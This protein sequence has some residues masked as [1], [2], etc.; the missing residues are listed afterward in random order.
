MMKDAFYLMLNTAKETGESGESA[1]GKFDLTHACKN[2][3][4]GYK[5]IGNLPVK[6]VK[7]QK[8]FIETMDRDYLI[9]DQLYMVFRSSTAKIPDFQPV[10]N[11]KTKA[12]LPY[13]HFKPDLFFP[14]MNNDSEGITTDEQCSVCK[15]NGYFDIIEFPANLDSENAINQVRDIP[16]K[17][18]YSNVSTELLNRSDIFYTWEYFGY[19]NLIATEKKVIGFAR[20]RIIVSEIVKSIFEKFPIKNV[21]F[22]KIYFV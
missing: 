20:P 15:Q 7:L 5:L 16:R 3:G 1:G 11:S 12:I 21:L 4:T 10:I 6:A 19:S 2:C 18:K 17:Y 8:D 22:E 9:S 14:K 13:S